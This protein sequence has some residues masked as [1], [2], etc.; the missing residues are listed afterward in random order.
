MYPQNFAKEDTMS[1][2]DNRSHDVTLSLIS[3]KHENEDQRWNTRVSETET[4]FDEKRAKSKKS[5]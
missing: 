3:E 1:R 2:K 5:R 4:K